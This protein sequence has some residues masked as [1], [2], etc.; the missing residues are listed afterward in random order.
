MSSTQRWRHCPR[1]PVAST[2]AGVGPLTYRIAKFN[3]SGLLPG[4][5]ALQV[6]MTGKVQGHKINTTFISIY[7]ARADTLSGVYTSGGSLSARMKIGLH[8]ARESA[9]NLLHG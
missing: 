3:A 6:H 1:G 8:A 7:Q 2:I 5:I 9:K 4:A